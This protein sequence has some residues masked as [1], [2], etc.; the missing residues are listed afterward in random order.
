MGYTKIKYSIEILNPLIDFGIALDTSNNQTTQHNGLGTDAY[1]DPQITDKYRDD[2]DL[3]SLGKTFIF[4]LTGQRPPYEED[5][6]WFDDNNITHPPVEQ[7]LKTVIERMIYPN[8]SKRFK[9]TKQLLKYI[10][11]QHFS[12]ELNIF[13]LMVLG[14]IVSLTIYCWTHSLAVNQSRNVEKKY[15]HPICS[16]YLPGKAEMNCGQITPSQIASGRPKIFESAF[17]DLNNPDS[18]KRDQAI[19]TYEKELVSPG[20]K[21]ISGELLIYLNNAR[22][23]KEAYGN[24]SQEVYTLIVSVPDYLQPPGAT[25]NLL[26]GIAQSQKYF[27]KYSKNLK[28]YVA[29]LKEPSKYENK[30]IKEI[31]TKVVEKAN[32]NHGKNSSQNTLK[33]FQEKAPNSRFIGVIGHYS[34][35]VTF[36]VLGLYKEDKILLVSP[37]ATRFD[38]PDSNT[39]VDDLEYFARLI[40]NGRGQVHEISNLLHYLAVDRS[41]KQN[42]KDFRCGLMN[43]TLIYEKGDTYANSVGNE[44]ISIFKPEN[45]PTDK[46]ISMK[47][48]GYNIESGNEETVKRNII[49]LIKSNS[50]L[51][52]INKCEVAQTVVFI[53]GAYTTLNNPSKIV[54]YIS[55]NLPNKVNFIGNITVADILSSE[56][57]RND[58]IKAK[59]DFYQ[60]AYISAP[61]SILD[62]LPSYFTPDKPVVNSV[63]FKEVVDSEESILDIQWRKVSGADSI[64]VFGE[65]IKQYKKNFE[66]YK[67]KSITEA[68]HDI[69][70]GKGF[71]AEGFFGRIEFDGYERKNM[72]KGTALKYVPYQD[73]ENK[74]ALVPLDY[75]DRNDLR[76]YVEKYKEL[77]FKDFV[78]F[79]P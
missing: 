60:R 48:Y 30:E 66:A 50:K 56:D 53:P 23:Q 8:L 11:N 14:F 29:I 3:Y 24:N 28:L 79:S 69:V 42:T 70:K 58:I 19:I 7:R 47:F 35:R 43:T 16:A 44:L 13:L 59:S 74:I 21:E 51:N 62:F 9:N 2:S 63:L 77:H 18:R 32:I 6:L 25:K 27:N 5:W 64:L 10:E 38:I 55:E 71:S 57:F 15:M 34:S 37:S 49:N 22:I 39:T 36:S 52:T 20:G 31:I 78:P 72:K 33:Y 76:K 46:N 45:M 4:L 73:K 67:N 61:Y 65:A 17:S 1:K 68:I 75:K 12:R 54:K 26:S 40:Y 41:N